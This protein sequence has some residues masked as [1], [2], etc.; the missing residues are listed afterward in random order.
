MD[1]PSGHK[2]AIKDIAEG[3]PVIKYG[4]PIGQ[5]K[6]HILKGEHVHASNIK[7]LLSESAAYHYSKEL[8]SQFQEKAEKRKAFWADKTPPTIQAY[9]RANGKIGIRN[10][11]WIVPTV[12]CVNK[13]AE[14]LVSW[15]NQTFSI[16]EFYD[17]IHVWN[18]PPYGCSQLGGDDHEATR[19][20]LA[21]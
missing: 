10:E 1:I 2:F 16:S 8:A 20:I 5:A 4:A 21:T 3:E 15:A 18:H 6:Q 9:R 12:G 13:V 14:T 19:T 7:T 11:L 17:G